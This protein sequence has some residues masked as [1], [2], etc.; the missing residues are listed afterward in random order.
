MKKKILSAGLTA[1]LSILGASCG[2]HQ[3]SGHGVNNSQSEAVSTD[4]S[5]K[6]AEK[7][8]AV[9]DQG[10]VVIHIENFAFEPVE[11]TVAI[12]TKVTWVNKDKV[13]HTATG[14]DKG[15]DSGILK[16]GEEFSHVFASP[17]TFGYHC[18]P[19][20]NMK[21]RIIVK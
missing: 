12:G 14:D 5:R 1:S 15:F 7:R 18:I 9:D 8:G 16:Q 6:S 19:H 20:P 17:G 2:P 10:S 11:I 13:P 3:G 4:E 21:A